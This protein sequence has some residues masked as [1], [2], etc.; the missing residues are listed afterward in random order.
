MSQES[1]VFVRKASGLVRQLAPQDS[2]YMNVIGVAAAVSIVALLF[3]APTTYPGAD[4]YI[5]LTIGLII[6]IP[7]G[8]TYAMLATAY[9]R[10]GGDYVYVSRIIHP[11]A[12]LTSSGLYLLANLIGVGQFPMFT[13]WYVSSLLGIAGAL[14]NSSAYAAWGA[15]VG[16]AEGT[17]AVAGIIIIWSAII[18]VIGVRFLAMMQ[19]IYFAIAAIGTIALF[20]LMAFSTY[21]MFVGN[22]NAYAAGFGTSYQDLITKATSL[23]FVPAQ[24][25][26][27][28]TILA[29]VFLFG[30]L[31]TAW[32]VMVAG[33]VKR[34]ARSMILGC[35]IGIFASWV[36]YMLTTALFYRSFGKEFTDAASWL[37]AT[38][39]GDYPLP[40]GPYLT[41]LIGFLSRNPILLGIIGV[42]FVCWGASLTP[43]HI[44]I[45]SRPM[46]AYAMDRVFPS[47]FA[48]VNERTHT[49]IF[50]TVVTTIA[51]LTTLVLTAYA[52]ALIALT[53]NV[54][55]LCTLY[56]LFTLFTGLVFPFVK[57]EMFEASPAMV[58][59]KIGPVPVISI[60]GGFSGIAMVL[61][62]GMYLLHPELSGPVSPLS[63]GLIVGWAIFF[64]LIYYI[65]RWY[66]QR[67]GLD[68]SLS[69]KE[70][71]PG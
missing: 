25:S 43:N 36:I 62:L 55:V 48:S 23:G 64:A 71:P 21:D 46:F 13:A 41:Y 17:V 61:A 66:W 28:I 15:W 16:T 29:T 12:G 37:A 19:R 67:K 45:C 2:F 8:W 30:Y 14:Y 57:K 35:V 38:H 26:W 11:S 50:S 58:K 49:P 69:Y 32:P 27:A 34:P 60:A 68:I 70:I 6:A 4:L 33:E 52:G 1:G 39:S 20:G 5:A 9:P 51:G 63:I 47:K 65:A 7:F 24:F 40:V 44:M 56:F 59:A 3:A 18:N 31:T 42:G 22:F 10:S 54:A 53:V